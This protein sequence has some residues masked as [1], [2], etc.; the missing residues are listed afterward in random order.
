LIERLGYLILDYQITD[1]GRCP[2]CDAKIAGVWP[3]S[4]DKV[5]LSSRSDLFYRGPR[6]V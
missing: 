6:R 5:R 3:D 2:N 1:D 4:A